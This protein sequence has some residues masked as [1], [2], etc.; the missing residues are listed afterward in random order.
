MG[1]TCDNKCWVCKRT[2]Q[3][4]DA[5]C[6]FC[7]SGRESESGCRCLSKLSLSTPSPAQVC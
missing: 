7:R 3:G 1:G 5:E 4:A 2:K 6:L